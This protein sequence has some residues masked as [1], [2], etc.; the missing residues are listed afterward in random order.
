[1]EVVKI[2]PERKLAIKILTDFEELLKRHNIKIPSDDREADRKNDACLY[3]CEYYELE[4]GIT[5]ILKKQRFTDSD[6]KFFPITSVHRDDI[7]EALRLSDAQVSKITDDMVR[8]I[9]KKMADDYC[10][11]LYWIHLPI[12]SQAVIKQKS[13]PVPER[14]HGA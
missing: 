7:K 13:R 11:Q 1:M 6:R 2:E 8:E 4:D 10:E 9:A 14:K 12:I 3:G 5:N